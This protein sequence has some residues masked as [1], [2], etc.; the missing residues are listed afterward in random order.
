[1]QNNSHISIFDFKN[2]LEFYW[3]SDFD[4]PNF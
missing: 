2:R 1:M 3:R 4:D